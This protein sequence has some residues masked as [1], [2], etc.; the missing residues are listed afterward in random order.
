MARTTREQRPGGW[1]RGGRSQ[2]Q[3]HK[4]SAPAPPLRGRLAV[5]T[6]GLRGYARLGQHGRVAGDSAAQGHRYICGR[7]Y[8]VRARC[9]RGDQ[10]DALPAWTHEL[11]VVFHRRRRRLCRCSE[12]RAEAARG[13][14]KVTRGAPCRQKERAR[15]RPLAKATTCPVTLATHIPIN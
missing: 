12:A 15:R 14:G 5:R 1:G 9:A 13:A 6:I 8:A 10:V 11:T 2:R 3:G 4:T 7:G